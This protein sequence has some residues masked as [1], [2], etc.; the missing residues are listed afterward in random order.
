M[1]IYTGLWNKYSRQPISNSIC[2]SLRR[3]LTVQVL[4]THNN[5]CWLPLAGQRTSSPPSVRGA[6]FPFLALLVTITGSLTSCTTMP[7]SNCPSVCLW[8]DHIMSSR[9]SRLRGKALLPAIVSTIA[10]VISRS[11]VSFRWLWKGCLATASSYLHRSCKVIIWKLCY[12]ETKQHIYSI[13][14]LS[15]SFSFPGR[16]IFRSQQ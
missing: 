10:V 7:L 13:S 5:N 16:T 9:T 6:S 2:R 8:Y 12:P 15:K 14:G 1:D 11:D 4:Q 3:F